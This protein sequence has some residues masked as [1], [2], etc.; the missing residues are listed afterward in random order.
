MAERAQDHLCHGDEAAGDQQAGGRPD[1]AQGEVVAGGLGEAQAQAPHEQV[2]G[3]AA[4][5]SDLFFFETCN[6]SWSSSLSAAIRLLAEGDVAGASEQPSTSGKHTRVAVRV[7]SQP[8][9]RS[10]DY[11]VNLRDYAQVLRAQFRLVLSWIAISVLAAGLLTALA[12]P[13]YRSVVTFFVST[14][15]GEVGPPTPEACSPAAGEVLHRRRA[16]PRHGGRRL[17]QVPG[18]GADLVQADLTAEAVPDTVLLRATVTDSDAHRAQD[19]AA[20]L[21]TVLPAAVE[22]L[23]TPDGKTGSPVKVSV[24]DQPQLALAPFA[25]RPVRNLA[26]GLSLGVLLG[27]ALALVRDGLDNRV[28]SERDALTATGAATIGTVAFDAAVVKA[29]LFVHEQGQS[30]RA[31]AFRQMRTNL[32]FLGVD[33]PIRSLVVTSS[34]PAEG[35]SVTV[36]NLALALAQAGVR[37][38]LVEGDLRRPRVADYLGLEGA[39]GLTT[40]LIGDAGVEDVLQPWGDGRL[41]VLPSGPIPPNPSELLASRGMESLLHDLREEFDIVLIDAPPLL[42]V[43]DGAVLSTLADG[44]LLVVRSHHTREDHLARA[45]ASLAAVD[46]R[47]LGVV[48]NMVPAGSG[49]TRRTATAATPPTSKAAHVER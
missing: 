10:Y 6:M 22:R 13:R 38:C 40:V 35:K 7:A 4:H 5:P 49:G 46:A 17:R 25:P 28:K 27:G 1:R 23:E 21:S 34:L 2:R 11:S 24:L 45:A 39:A 15:S 47:V 9:T 8:A 37:V 19:I 29:P 48:L 42:P 20:A 12:R 32:Q 30:T 41:Q 43:T 33:E 16:R 14:P 26:L 3:E 31:E 44:A 36:C 18:V